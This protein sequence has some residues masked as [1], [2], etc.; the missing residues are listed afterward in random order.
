MRIGKSNE[1]TLPE[2][3]MREL[4]VAP[5]DLV[6]VASTNGTVV[7]RKVED[8][9]DRARRIALANRA[10]LSEDEIEAALR[11]AKVARAAHAAADDER[12][13]RG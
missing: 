1:V 3:V 11:E 13:K 7:L 10:P 2:E 6:E 9:I 12:I 8:A 4:E 5:G